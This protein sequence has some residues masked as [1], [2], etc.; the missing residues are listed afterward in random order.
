[1]LKAVK[2][3]IRLMDRIRVTKNAKKTAVFFFV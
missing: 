1:V 3:E 2:A